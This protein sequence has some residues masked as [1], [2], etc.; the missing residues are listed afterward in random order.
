MGIL[1][2]FVTL[3]LSASPREQSLSQKEGPCRSSSGT[4]FSFP[5]DIG[6]EACLFA[7]TGTPYLHL[8]GSDHPPRFQGP[9]HLTLRCFFAPPGGILS[10]CIHT[11]MEGSE[12]WLRLS[13]RKDWCASEKV[14]LLCLQV[15]GP[16][17]AAQGGGASVIRDNSWPCSRNHAV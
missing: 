11:Q 8:R 5:G 1:P 7:W 14:V 12:L 16:H 4:F 15:F 10:N 9:L 13:L 17:L 2:P 6:W 3:G